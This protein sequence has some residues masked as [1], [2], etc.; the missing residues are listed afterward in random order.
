VKKIIVLLM[1]IVRLLK[2]LEYYAR[3]NSK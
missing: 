2:E 1:E 3:R